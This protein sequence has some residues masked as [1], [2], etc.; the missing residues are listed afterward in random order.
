MKTGGID[1][2]VEQS[3]LA[4]Q[5]I[6]AATNIYDAAAKTVF[7]DY[8]HVAAFIDI[9]SW[10]IRNGCEQGL[11]DLLVTLISLPAIGGYNR[12][13]AAMIAT[14]VISPE[15]MG[16]AIS[17]EGMKLIKEQIDAKRRTVQVEGNDEGK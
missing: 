8:K 11:E 6:T 14:G 9:F 13:I 16:V 7:R 17:K 2:P 3:K 12:S 10:C 5:F 4:E 1:I 15:A